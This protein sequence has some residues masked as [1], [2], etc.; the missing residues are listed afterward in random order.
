[1]QSLYTF[2]AK[3]NKDTDSLAKVQ[4]AYAVLAIV[5]LLVAGLVSLASPNLG[6][7]MLFFAV[8]LGLTF[9]GNGVMWALVRTFALPHIE[10]S[11]P[12]PTRKK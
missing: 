5:M 3:W 1:M 10:K 6:Q 12:K 2:L 8:V 4:G 7:S 9:I 11:A